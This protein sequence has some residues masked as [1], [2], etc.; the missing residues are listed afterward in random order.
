[1]EVKNR[2]LNW[3]SE[4]KEKGIPVEVIGFYQ[5]LP[6]RV[7]TKLIDFDENFLQWE[8][9]PK[10][11]LTASDDG[12]FF[13]YFND[14][15]YREKRLLGADVTYYGNSF[16]ET[17]FPKPFSDPRFGRQ[18]VRVTT[19]EKLPVKFYLLSESGEKLLSRLGIFQRNADNENVK[20]LI[21]LGQER[22]SELNDLS[23]GEF[24]AS[25][26]V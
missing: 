26:I 17:S 24:Y 8:Y 12:K 19:S 3:L 4:L 25:E 6:I 15:L 20:A 1:M 22:F 5:E 16:I 11:Y 7:K 18:V 23:F 10:L 14:P 2:I 21:D 13:F 9:N